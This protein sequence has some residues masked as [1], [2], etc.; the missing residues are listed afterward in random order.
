MSRDVSTANMTELQ[1]DNPTVVI[2][3]ELDLYDVLGAAQ[4]YVRFCSGRNTLQVDGNDFDAVGGFLNIGT[5]SENTD[6]AAEK[7]VVTL[8]GADADNLAIIKDYRYQNRAS[9]LWLGTLDPVTG[10]LVDNPHKVHA[11]RMDNMILNVGEESATISVH[12]E[13]HM[14]RAYRPLNR[15]YTQQDQVVEFPADKG[16]EFVNSIVDKQINW[17]QADEQAPGIYG[18]SAGGGPKYDT[19]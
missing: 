14:L 16:L 6:M 2:F 1:K 12:I 18:G 4:E 5:V 19:M 7:F 10:L 15:R 11:G 9:S 17:G 3:V 8:S 13:D